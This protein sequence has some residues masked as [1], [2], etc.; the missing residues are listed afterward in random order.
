MEEIK[1]FI[2]TNI[3]KYMFNGAVI[4]ISGG[5]DSAVVGKLLVDSIG[6]DK[7]YGLILPERDSSP[8]TVDDAKLVCDYLGIEYKIINITGILRKLGIYSL[9]PPAFPFPKSVQSIYSR[10]I[11]RKEKN[12]FIQDLTTQGDEKFLEALAYYRT[13]PRI[14]STVLYFEAEKINYAVIGCINKTEYTIGFYTKWGDEACDIEPIRHLYK[15]E[16][17]E[18]AKKLNIPQKII[19]KKPSPDIAPGITDEFALGI[20]YAELDRILMKIERKEDLSSENED[21]VEKIKE[22]LKFK[23]FREAKQLHL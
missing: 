5:L 6:R 20:D 14:R 22:M 17:L 12:P 16:V 3:E 11:W 4:G 13:K 21:S 9:K 7:V 18:L 19:D 1:N 8:E 10:N 2:K 15:T 23:D